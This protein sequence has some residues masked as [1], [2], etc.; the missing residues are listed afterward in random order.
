[1][2]LSKAL[3]VMVASLLVMA[4]GVFTAQA[5]AFGPGH[6]KC[7][8][9]P[10]FGGLK[11]FLDLKLTDAQQGEMMNIIN[12][13]ENE[14]EPLRNRMIE[15]R[16]SLSAA[17]HAEQFNE[18]D[19]RKAFKE[20]SETR[21]EMFV[22]GARMMAEL[23]TVL[24]PEQKEQLKERRTQRRERMKHRLETRLERLGE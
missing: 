21:E 10:G 3:A 14:R 16:R 19:A 20:V 23:K 5:G 1:M 13:F 6:Q 8:M 22:L 4:G 24:T 17:L 18:I 7:G 15:A 12:K 9:G 11:A 2:R